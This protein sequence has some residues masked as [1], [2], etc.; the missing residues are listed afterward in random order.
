MMV[1]LV[2]DYEWIA[3]YIA[4]RCVNHPFLLNV[5]RGDTCVAFHYAYSQ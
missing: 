3:K 1:E 2:K 5:A 4:T